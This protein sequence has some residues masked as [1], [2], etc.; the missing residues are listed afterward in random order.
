ML[1][2]L[3][4]S[5]FFLDASHHQA[6]LFPAPRSRSSSELKLCPTQAPACCYC[7]R[8]RHAGWQ[9]KAGGE[10]A[11]AVAVTVTLSLIVIVTVNEPVTVTAFLAVGV[12]A[13]AAAVA[14][15]ATVRCPGIREV[16]IPHHHLRKPRSLCHRSRPAPLTSVGCRETET[17]ALWDVQLLFGHGHGDGKMNRTIPLRARGS[18]PRMP[19]VLRS[20]SHRR[21]EQE[22]DPR[23][24]RRPCMWYRSCLA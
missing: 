22:R 9:I 1:S 18:A 8:R 23:R 12:A 15:A 20:H 10:R 24:D 4:L 13:A 16:E 3:G 14:V 19:S 2:P 6:L 5:F 21:E 17:Q 11:V 7:Y